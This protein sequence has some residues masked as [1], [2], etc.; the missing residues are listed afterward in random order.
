MLSEIKRRHKN[1]K[2]SMKKQYSGFY[3]FLGGLGVIMFWYGIW[4]G[5]KVIPIV[6]HPFIAMS[7]GFLLMS[8]TGLLVFELI[9]DY[10]GLRTD[11]GQVEHTNFAEDRSRLAEHYIEEEL[12]EEFFS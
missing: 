6:G 2:N 7:I 1:W 8:L 5:L 10:E 12:V 4:E 9:G 3:A 11:D